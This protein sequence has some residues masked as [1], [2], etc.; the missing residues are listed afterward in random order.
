[1]QGSCHEIILRD[2]KVDI[3]KGK[4]LDMSQAA[5]A[6]R[7]H[8]IVR[9]A[10]GPEDMVNS[11]IVVI[12]AGAPRT[13]GMSRDD[14]LI[15]NAEIVKRY[16]LEIKKYASNSIVIVVSNPLDVMTYVALKYTGFPRERVLGMAGILDAAR[17][18]H[19]IYEKLGYGAGQ[20][21]ATVMGGHGDTMVPLPK[22]TTV[23]GVPIDDLLDSEE[24]GEIVKKT[25]N[26]GAQ[27]VNLLGDGS[28]Y[29]APAKSTAV[30]VD[31]ILKDTKQIHSCA[32][33]LQDDY[34]YSGM[35]S[36]VPVMIGAGGAEQVI[37][38][39]LK[40]LQKTRFKNSVASVQEM[41]D[42][43]YTNKFFDDLKEEEKKGAKK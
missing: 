10:A 1:M 9:A 38:M 23:A 3:A 11:E 42:T 8:T 35:V 41:V 19:F 22:F 16:S 2:N 18:A 4:A 24:I 34:G 29:Y 36:G 43:L 31:A 12:T 33:M 6:A 39:T 30:M 7:E 25:R 28:A 40:T 15:K 21:R 27:I 14:L 13:P 32:V 17:M 5:N 20:I 26:G 37:E